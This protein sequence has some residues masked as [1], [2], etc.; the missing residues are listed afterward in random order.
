MNSLTVIS[1]K[2][3]IFSPK[4]QL[5]IENS[6]FVKTC[7]ENVH[8]RLRKQWL[9]KELPI[10]GKWC[11]RACSRCVGNTCTSCTLTWLQRKTNK[12]Q[13]IN[14]VCY[15]SSVN[16][17]MSFSCHQIDQNSNEIL[18][19][20]SALATYKNFVGFLVDLVTPKEHFEIN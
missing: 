2:N 7:D 5:Q 12:H 15:Q 1:I 20:I 16:F 6:G 13:K 3:P 17:E 4:N 8:R 10:S 18:V 14:Y 9:C 19:R 11:A